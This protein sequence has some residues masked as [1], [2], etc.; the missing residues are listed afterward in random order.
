M[1]KTKAPKGRKAARKN[2][3]HKNT[4]PKRGGNRK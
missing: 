3:A 4:A 2:R 1:K